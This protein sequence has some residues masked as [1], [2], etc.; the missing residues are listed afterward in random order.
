VREDEFR[1]DLE[2]V[3]PLVLSYGADSFNIPQ[4][5]KPW[6]IPLYASPRDFTRKCHEGFKL[7]QRRLLDILISIEDEMKTISGKLRESRRA[8]ADSLKDQLN[9]ELAKLQFQRASFREVAN[10]IAWTIFGMER[11][12]IRALMK[13]GMGKGYLR[14][15]NIASVVNEADRINSDP[16]SFALINDITSCVGVGDLI[17]VKDL[18]K[19]IVEVKEGKV[20]E[21]IGKMLTKPSTIDENYYS[22]LGKLSPAKV[23]D[24]AERTV[25]QIAAIGNA[26]EYIRTDY[27]EKDG[28]TGL[29]RFAVDPTYAPVYLW[30]PVNE[31]VRK[32]QVGQWR[33]LHAGSLIV[34]IVKPDPSYVSYVSGLDFQHYMYHEKTVPWQKCRYTNRA[35]DK[36]MRPEF[37]EYENTPIYSMRDRV[38]LLDRIPIFAMLGARNG[39]DVLTDALR[40]YVYFDIDSFYQLCQGVG[41]EPAWISEKEFRRS[42][43]RQPYRMFRPPLF[44]KGHLSFGKGDNLRVLMYGTLESLVYELETGFSVARKLKTKPPT[45]R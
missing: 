42:L 37:M 20:N 18:R 28:M 4:Q 27:T 24:Q 13:F 8:S 33:F 29:P 26:I 40:I 22:T 1:E 12:H 39:I 14:D 45:I 7:A 34:G 23:L 10:V 43:G 5:T 9:T 3:V 15:R 32:I 6:E 25:R 16:D 30:E 19:T 11:A 31:I 2:L 36:S 35:D 41:L 38:F 17:V 44:S 21:L